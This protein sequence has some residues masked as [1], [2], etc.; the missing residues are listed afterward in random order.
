MSTALLV[1]PPNSSGGNRTTA[2]RWAR[3]LRAGGWRV[4]RAPE[5]N[6]PAAQLIIAVHA[7]KTR[8]QVA[9]LRLSHPGTPVVVAAAGTDLYVDL[10]GGGEAAAEARAGFTAADRI[11]VLQDRAL[12]ALPEDLRSRARVIHQSTPELLPKPDPDPTRFEVLMLA[13][14]REVKDPMCAARAAARLSE[15]SSVVVN[16]FGPGLDSVL[17]DRVRGAAGPRYRWHGPIPRS[18][19][20]C[21]LTRAHLLVS[22]SREE[23]GANVLTE[24][25]AQGT[26]VLA[27]RIDGAVGLL[28]DDHPGLYPVGDDEALARLLVRCEGDAGFLEELRLRSRDRAWMADPARERAAWCS[29]LQDLEL[30]VPS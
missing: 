17:E 16:H 27:T 18:E 1:L 8:A 4:V 21:R 12:E 14:V 20:L 29:L 15:D 26:A 23:G 10:P 19:A 11:V 9:S 6:A 22:P 2:L 30:E 13:G 5:R 3:I 7:T 28:G 24:A 25:F